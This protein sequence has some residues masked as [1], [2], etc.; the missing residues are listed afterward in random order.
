MAISSFNRSL[1]QA[2]LGR[3]GPQGAAEPE[4]LN[5]A[6]EPCCTQRSLSHP[7]KDVL[8]RAGQACQVS[9]EVYQ[10]CWGEGERSQSHHYCLGEKGI[11]TALP[12]CGCLGPE[13]CHPVMEEQ[14][15]LRCRVLWRGAALVRQGW[16]GST[17]GHCQT[18][19]WVPGLE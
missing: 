17:E 6:P 18:Y 7:S 8:G 13:P 11:D 5:G 9:S 1:L 2:A 3:K 19:M 4:S 15:R 12:V 10:V 14:M 16:C